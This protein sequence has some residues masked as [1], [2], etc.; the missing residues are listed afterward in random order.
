MVQTQN[1]IGLALTAIGQALTHILTSD[2]FLDRDAMVER[3]GDAGRLLAGQFHQQTRARRA[4][5]L[6]KVHDRTYKEVLQATTPDTFLFEKDLGERLKSSRSV[7]TLTKA[8]F[9]A[10]KATFPKRTSGNERGLGRDFQQPRSTQAYREREHRRQLQF[11][12]KRTYLDKIQP[13]HSRWDN[14]G[15]SKKRQ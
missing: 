3:I 7:A 14:P 4:L 9:Q 10:P 15:L 8:I 6:P 2:G 12:A 1:A 5:I 13:G 11:G